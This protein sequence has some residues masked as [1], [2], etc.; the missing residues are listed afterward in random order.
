M[1][2]FSDI[3]LS[4]IDAQIL[5]IIE[6]SNL[7]IKE[8]FYKEKQLSYKKGFK[9]ANNI[10]TETDKVVDDYLRKELGKI[11][12][13]I[14]F[15]T[16][17]GE[18]DLKELN[19][20]IDPI[21]ATH[22]FANNIPLFG[23]M[24]ALWHKNTPLYGLITF[25]MLLETV[26]AISGRGLYLNGKKIMR[27][28]TK[29]PHIFATYGYVGS[30]DD[31]LKLLNAIKDIVGVASNYRATCYHIAMTALGRMDATLM[32]DLALWDIAAGAILAKEAGLS[33][34][35]IKSLPDVYTDNGEYK[36]KVI[37][38]KPELEAKLSKKLK[39]IF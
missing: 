37:M 4:Q 22:N 14:G 12:S 38:A 39:A 34:R 33:Y 23:T 11:S 17:E 35:Y 2:N 9:F 6:N 18:H 1:A 21:D 7:I 5:K 16:E 10:L 3:P 32:I 19:W 26:H 30:A 25:P 24:I 13:E 28:N 36:Y 8:A 29:H 20:I 15:L 31:K 27:N